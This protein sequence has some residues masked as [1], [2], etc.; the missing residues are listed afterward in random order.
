MRDEDLLGE[1]ERAPEPATRDLGAAG[2]ALV[3]GAYQLD[4]GVGSD[5]FGGV[6][7]HA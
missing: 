5:G 1:G 3:R 6:L 2:E 7:S 4:G